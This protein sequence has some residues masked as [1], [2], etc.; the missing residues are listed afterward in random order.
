MVS[1]HRWSSVDSGLWAK[2]VERLVAG[3]M[4][5]RIRLRLQESGGALNGT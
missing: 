3:E 4:V 1:M 2:G 5:V